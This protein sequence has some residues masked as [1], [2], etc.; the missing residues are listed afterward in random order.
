MVSNHR[1]IKTIVELSP[2]S[3]SRVFNNSVLSLQAVTLSITD[4][5]LKIKQTFLFFTFL[6][7]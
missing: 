2:E 4:Y 1:L 7:A 6:S 5:R 3:R